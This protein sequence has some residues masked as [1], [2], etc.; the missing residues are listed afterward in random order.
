MLNMSPRKAWTA[1]LFVILLVGCYAWY[2]AS[3]LER[4]DSRSWF[5]F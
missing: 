1:V 3:N 4:R 5:G 2:I